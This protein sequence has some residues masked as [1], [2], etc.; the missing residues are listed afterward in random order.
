MK[1]SN[2]SFTKENLNQALE[3]IKALKENS[4][5]LLNSKPTKIILKGFLL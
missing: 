4:T 2:K 5:L 1:K 3:K